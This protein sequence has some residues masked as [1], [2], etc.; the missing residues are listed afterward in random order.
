MKQLK[1]VLP[2]IL[3][4][5]AGIFIVFLILDDYNPTMDFINNPVSLKLF[6]SFCI[7]TLVNSIMTIITNRKEWRKNNG[8]GTN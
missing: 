2:H 5:L 1:S 4:I 6:W 8:E 7:L 3:L